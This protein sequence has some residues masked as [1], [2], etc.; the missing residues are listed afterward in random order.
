[1][2]IPSSKVWLPD[3]VLYNKY[4]L[5][6]KLLIINIIIIIVCYCLISADGDYQITTNTKVTINYDGI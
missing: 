4:H 5:F 1:M 6:F 3:I 2:N